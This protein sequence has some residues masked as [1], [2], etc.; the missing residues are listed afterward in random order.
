MLLPQYICGVMMRVM[1]SEGISHCFARAIRLKIEEDAAII[2]S[3]AVR[4]TPTVHCTAVFGHS[5]VCV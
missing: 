2:D 3:S 4:R 5:L 1:Y